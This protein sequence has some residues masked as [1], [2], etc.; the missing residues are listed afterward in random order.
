MRQ[1]PSAAKQEVIDMHSKGNK[2]SG[3][4]VAH[5]EPSRRVDPFYNNDMYFAPDQLRELGPRAFAPDLF[6]DR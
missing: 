6:P 3:W 1:G 2:D 5:L 4:E